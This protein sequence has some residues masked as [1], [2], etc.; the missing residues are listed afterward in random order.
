MSL[1]SRKFQCLEIV[2]YGCFVFSHSAPLAHRAFQNR[3][4]CEE[5][6]NSFPNFMADV[7][8][9]K[10]EYK[11]HF[12]GLFSEKDDAVPLVLFHGWP[13]KSPFPLHLFPTSKQNIRQF[14]RISSHLGINEAKIQPANTPLPYHRPL[15]SRLRILLL[16]TTESRF[17]HG[18]YR[19]NHESADARS[20]LWIWIYCSRR[21]YWESCC[22][23]FRW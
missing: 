7:I 15:S 21:R 6:M 8:I 9:G 17:R 14:P 2:P 13:G 18:R 19:S 3:R 4:K 20:G 23:D 1:N 10:E 16:T 12:V 11:I 22:E 5:H